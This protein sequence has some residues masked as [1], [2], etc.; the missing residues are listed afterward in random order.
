[1]KKLGIYVTYNFLI[2]SALYLI[3]FIIFASLFWTWP[4]II[5]IEDKNNALFGALIGAFASIVV[6]II[7]QACTFYAVSK[8]NKFNRLSQELALLAPRIERLELEQ[9][10]TGYAKEQFQTIRDKANN[11]GFNPPIKKTI[12]SVHDFLNMMDS[13]EITYEY[14]NPYVAGA[15]KKS[16]REFRRHIDYDKKMIGKYRD[17]VELLRTNGLTEEATKIHHERN[18]YIMGLP[19]KYKTIDFVLF[20]ARSQI[21]LEEIDKEF[22]LFEQ[23][24]ARLEKEFD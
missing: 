12:S 8:Q 17:D 22:T 20:D 13:I 10:E 4:L 21:R 2:G 16:Y 15:I 6:F 9:Y 14:I 11:F 18:E 5:N 7:G 23:K 3:L 19:E 24:K 1:M